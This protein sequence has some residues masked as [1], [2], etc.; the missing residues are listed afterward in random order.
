MNDFELIE[1]RPDLRHDFE[2]LNLP[3][4]EEHSLLE[5]LD[6]EYLR[7][8]GGRILAGGGQVFFAVRGAA[9]LGTCAAIRISASRFELAKLAVDPA[10]RGFGAGRRLCEAV[11]QYAR[12]NGAKEIVLTSNTAL[13]T[14]IRL[15][16]SLGFRHEPVPPDVQY[17]TA[18][19]F[20]RMMLDARD[21][22]S[23]PWSP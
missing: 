22:F 16:E 18:D 8:P 9:V 4:L 1:Y 20:M 17:V 23:K 3:W 15:Y 12:Q 13:S 21:D 6:L 10:A 19:V 11:I 2:R 7:D 5:P 14:A